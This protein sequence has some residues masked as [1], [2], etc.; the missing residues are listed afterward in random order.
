MIRGR[1][2]FRAAA[3][4]DRS[5][6]FVRLEP[7]SARDDSVVFSDLNLALGLA[8]GFRRVHL[9]AIVRYPQKCYARRQI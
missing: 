4:A 9:R 7:H 3:P 5:Y 2:G 6:D 1:K 8:A